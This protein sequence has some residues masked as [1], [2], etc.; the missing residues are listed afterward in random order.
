MTKP[1][2]GTAIFM[3]LEQGKLSLED[4]V[5]TY[6]PFFDNDKCRN[7]TIDHLLMHTSGFRS[8]QELNKKCNTLEEFV[9][10][11]SKIGPF[12]EPGSQLY[13]SGRNT[14]FLAYIIECITNTKPEDWIQ[15]NIL[16]PLQM[17][18]TFC[19]H[20]RVLSDSLYDRISHVYVLKENKYEKHRDPSW[21]PE[22]AYFGGGVGFYS[23]VMDYAKFLAMWLG[24]NLSGKQII[25]KSST[26][27]T[28]VQ[29]SIFDRTSARHWEIF[30]PVAEREKK[31]P[32]FGHFGDFGTMAYATP[33]SELII[34]FFTQSRH[35]E[36][37]GELL[38]LFE[39]CLH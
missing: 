27:K 4:K 19:V 5:L 9:I 34:C 29:S 14:A 2:V 39:S 30:R 36:I 26:V 18:D 11:A 24:R 23:T 38:T 13:Y 10:E 15:T 25:N 1:L 37:F 35:N 3:L 8:G 20:N 33:E 17:N 28:A 6:I 7:V 32:A 12:S 31:L 22:F 21:N 16:N